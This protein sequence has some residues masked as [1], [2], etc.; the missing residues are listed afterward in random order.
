[1]RRSREPGALEQGPGSGDRGQGKVLHT[2]GIVVFYDGACELCTS[3]RA[4]AAERDVAGRLRF[5]NFRD[6]SVGALPVA[7]AQ[8][9][10]EMWVRRADGSLCAGFEGACAV[11]AA[12]PRWRWVAAVAGVP[13]L[14]WLG[15]LVYRVVARHRA[16]L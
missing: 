13:P 11:F 6:A 9:E 2:S 16:K 10:R 7:R 5:V 4:W 15:W 12:L 8:L 3:T 1:M 14:R